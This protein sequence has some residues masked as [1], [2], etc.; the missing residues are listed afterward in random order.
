[1]IRKS[2]S[3]LADVLRC[4]HVQVQSCYGREFKPGIKEKCSIMPKNLY[5]Y[6]F[7][8]IPKATDLSGSAN[9]DTSASIELPT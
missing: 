4:P 9:D 6:V 3:V 2:A 1:M 7:I 5:V 8:T